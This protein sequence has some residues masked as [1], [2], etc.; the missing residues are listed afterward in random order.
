[1]A[2]RHYP[3]TLSFS[4]TIPFDEPLSYM[5]EYTVA[6]ALTFI[7][8]TTNAQ[9][10]FG[11]M[12]RLVANGTNTPDLTDFALEG[13]GSWVNTVGTVNKCFFYYD[14]TQYCVIITQPGAGG[15][16]TGGDSTPPT[17]NGMIATDATTI[18]VTFNESVNAAILTGWSFKKNGSALATSA[19]SAITSTVWQFTVATMASGDTITASYDSTTGNVQNLAGLDLA[20]FT[21]SAVTN[22]IVGFDSDADAFF[23]AAGITDGTQK[24]AI[25][26]LVLDLKSASV[27]TKTKALYPFVGGTATTH[28]YNLKDPQDLD[29][30]FRISFT[31]TWTHNANG[32]MGD[33]SSAYGNTHFNPDTQFADNANAYLGVYIGGTSESGEYIQVGARDGSADFY[34]K[35]RSAGGDPHILINSQVTGAAVVS[36]LGYTSGTQRTGGNIRTFKNGTALTPLTAHT[37]GTAAYDVYVG[38][39]NNLGTP[40]GYIN[41]TLRT[42]IICD[43]EVSDAEDLAIYNAVS[44]FNTTLS[45]A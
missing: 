7:K 40:Y 21:D 25:N 39:L 16:G 36:P 32:A 45:R 9:V 28:K 33:G 11:C 26:Q 12:V 30:S 1:M 38:A 13:P 3:K 27:W 5:P 2:N 42:I 23:T 24:S 18:A 17:I 15:T 22:S 14:G 35:A 44:N 19:V 4:Q 29:A 8:S 10:G 6:G 20:S 37:P 31:G 43:D 41:S 34:I